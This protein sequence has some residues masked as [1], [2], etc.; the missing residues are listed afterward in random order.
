MIDGSEKRNIVSWLLKVT[1]RMFVKSAAMFDMDDV[2]HD[3]L[4]LHVAGI[5]LS[6]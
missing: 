3:L 5:F 6:V 4:E 1:I 2:F